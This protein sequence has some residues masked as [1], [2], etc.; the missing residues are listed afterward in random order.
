M[1]GMFQEEGNRS[2]SSEILDSIDKLEK[3]MLSGKHGKYLPKSQQPIFTK[4]D[5]F[6]NN[7]ISGVS[8]DNKKLEDDKLTSS[9]AYQIEE[10]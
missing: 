10:K 1:E 7:D 6:V 8:D 9:I 2:H 4:K 5:P 3:L